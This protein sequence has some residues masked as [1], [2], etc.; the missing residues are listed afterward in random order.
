MPDREPEG[1]VTGYLFKV[2]RE[3]IPRTQEELSEEL[4][5]DKSTLQGWE[6]G[7]RPLSSTKAG[8]LVAMR[9]KL[10]LLGA[11]PRL[12]DMLPT[13]LDADLLLGEILRAEP[14]K[15]RIDEHP[16]AGWVLT[17]DTTHM[18]G[19]AVSG[20]LPGVVA[21][22]STIPAARRGPVSS[23]PLLEPALRTRFFQ[24][25]RTASDVAEKAGADAALLR[26]QVWYLAS[27]DRQWDAASWFD[28]L[29]RRG[30]LTATVDG[31]S[32]RWAEARSVAAALARQGDPTL[33]R[34]FINRSI[35]DHDRAE[36]AN[37]NYWAHWLGL[38]SRPQTDDCF[39]AERD[40]P[41]WDASALLRELAVRLDRAVEYT[42]LY[43]HSIWAL[44][45][46]RRSLLD[47]DPYVARELIRRVRVLLDD[48]T[49]SS[50][51]RRRLESVYYGLRIGGYDV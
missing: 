16:L 6:S 30:V 21:A 36:A 2:I 27:Y 44:V 14:T 4:G 9:R 29:R 51:S 11:P 42:D 41:V 48:G 12:V 15:A 10:I 50:E 46:F 39:M 32:P 35:A 43:I 18:I 19:W 37:L 20:V 25:L 13:A 28:G 1:A 8:N 34:D 31:W 17:R 47:S 33:M 24:K 40:R 26:R 5:I 49:L 7:R 23:S 3:Q 45:L 22:H 38:D